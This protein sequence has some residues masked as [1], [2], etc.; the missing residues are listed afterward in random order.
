MGEA[1]AIVV[2]GASTGIGRA[3]VAKAAQEGAHVFAAVRKATDADSLKAEFGAA[4]TPL[5]MD[6]AKPEEIAAAAREVDARLDGRRLFGLVNNAGVAVPGP[7]PLMETSEL[8]RQFEINLFGAHETTR[9]FLPL[10]GMDEARTGPKGRIVM[11]SSVGGRIGNPILGAYAASKHALEGY[12]QSL[13]RD[14]LLYG[15]DV[16]VVA[17]AAVNTPIWAKDEDLARYRGTDYDAT[18]AKLE[19]I[20]KR[21]GDEGLPASA[22]A[23]AV[24]RGLTDARPRPRVTVARNALTSDVLPRLLPERFVNRM[25]ARMLHLQPKS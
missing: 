9:A 5:F 4:V 2:T 18:L 1:R 15:I 21:L 3:C 11:M 6:V 13:R 16:I 23:D 24:W 19:K 17:P 22:V 14:L 10:L 7:L 8:K 12:S 25:M 20:M